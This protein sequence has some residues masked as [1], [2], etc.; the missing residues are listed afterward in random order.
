MF[1]LISASILLIF[2]TGCV[3]TKNSVIPKGY[4]GGE[5]T[6]IDTYKR[7]SRSTADFY[8]A[9]I[10]NGEKV[11]YALNKSASRSSGQNRNL[12]LIGQDKKIP[13]TS[14]VSV[15]IIGNAFN[16]LPIAAL[17]NSDEAHFVEGNV[18]F[19]PKNNLSYLVNGTLSAQY[20]AVWIEDEFGNIVSDVISKGNPKTKASD[21][22]SIKDYRSQSPTEIFNSLKGGETFKLV[23]KKLGQPMSLT[24]FINKKNISS[25]KYKDIGSVQFSGS[26][27][28]GYYL[29][30]IQPIIG[31]TKEGLENIKRLLS[32]DHGGQ[33]RRTALEFYDRDLSN[34]AALDLFAQKLWNSKNADH[35]NAV[36]AMSWICKMLAKSGEDRYYD[37]LAKISIESTES[38]LRKYAKESLAKLSPGAKNIFIPN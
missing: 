4:S 12:T 23:N 13:T 18:S 19:T 5:A 29:T 8:Y 27:M 9:T 25:F 2:S 15:H 14:P 37:L 20:S 3:S 31:N 26:Q 24:P 22:L 6:I 30:A 10:I 11:A 1:K 38:K 21:L 33:L 17:F 28:Y 36:D 34:T 7:S 16:V 35:R 32:T